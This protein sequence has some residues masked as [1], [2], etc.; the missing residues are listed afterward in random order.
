[1]F[2]KN[3]LSKNI[4]SKPLSTIEIVIYSTEKVISTDKGLPLTYITANETTTN[5][6][7]H[8]LSQ[9]ESDLLKAVLYFSIQPDKIRKSS[10]L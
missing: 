9:E 10:L 2:Q 4:S 1:M 7:Q 6:A 3:C 8:V 5:L